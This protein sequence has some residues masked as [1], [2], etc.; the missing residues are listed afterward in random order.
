MSSFPL[1][2][3]GTDMPETQLPLLYRN[4][5]PLNR[6]RH[7]DWYVDPDQGY[8][9]ASGTNSIYLSASEFAVAAREYAIVFARDGG[10]TAVP[11]VLLGLA[12]DQN[13]LVGTDGGWLGGYV[14]AYLRRYPYMLA[15]GQAQAEQFTVCVDETYSGFNTAKE[16]ERL[17]AEG[18]EQSAYL[19]G[20]V[21]FLQDF[22]AA[23]QITA[24]FCEAVVQAD[25]LDS[26]QAN[27]SL[28]SGGS[29]SLAGFFCVT[30]GRLLKLVPEQLKSFM[31]QGYLDL[32]YLH[33]HSLANLDKLMQLLEPPAAGA[34][35]RARKRGGKD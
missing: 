33:M 20:V 12:T 8:S 9:F 17:L 13:L 35:A 1:S 4:V 26:T 29:Y 27:I 2:I 21:K 23:S 34:K 32:I 10:G 14:P 7:A 28:N 19:L 15:N 25:L 3:A 16:G 6:E 22:L 24:K 5:T 11:A 18:G 30:P 31:E